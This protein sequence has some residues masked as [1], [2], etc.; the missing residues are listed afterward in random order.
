M[1]E[2]W[3]VEDERAG[4]VSSYL[5]EQQAP[6]ALRL[7][8]FSCNCDFSLWLWLFSLPTIMRHIC[9]QDATMKLLF[10]LFFLKNLYGLNLP[11]LLLLLLTS[12]IYH[13]HYR[14]LLIP[15]LTRVISSCGPI[16]WPETIRGTHQANHFPSD[17]TFGSSQMCH[18]NNNR[19]YFFFVLFHEPLGV[20]PWLEL[21]DP[22]SITTGF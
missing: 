2:N 20:S 15:T 13:T 9:D 8:T 12:S 11:L 1:C 10:C 22:V 5:P 19:V 14:Q 17:D 4:K 21:T 18:M 6:E 3:N 16:R 7:C